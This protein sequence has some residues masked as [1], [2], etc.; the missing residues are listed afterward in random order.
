MVVKLIAV[1][2]LAASRAARRTGHYARVDAGSGER[3][4]RAGRSD[5]HAI[6]SGGDRARRRIRDLRAGSFGSSCI[7]SIA[8][9]SRS[10]I[11]FRPTRCPCTTCRS[12]S[13]R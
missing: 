13:R 7:S 1:A 10:H 5:D 12:S 2:L 11:Q 4:S 3:E 8:R 6:V 9:V